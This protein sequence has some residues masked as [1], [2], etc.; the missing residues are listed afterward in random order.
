VR[1]EA[2]KA[3]GNV[4]TAAE[5][6]EMVGMLTNEWTDEERAAIGEAII[7]VSRRAPS[8]RG[9]T[10]PITKSLTS[11]GSSEGVKLTLISILGAVEDDSCLP[12]LEGVARK[13]GGRVQRAAVETLAGWPTPLPLETL[14]KVARGDKD[15]QVQAA[16][17]E[18]ALRQLERNAG[19]PEAQRIK[20]YQ[21]LAL[22]AQTPEHKQRIDEGLAALTHP[23]AAKVRTKIQNTD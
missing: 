13:P 9:R 5:L 2:L 3:L 22:V 1:L 18:G 6:D 20:H 19:V 15:P 12:A 8:G 10:D 7:S 4:G 14:D 16:A 11:G 21:S 23:D 17:I